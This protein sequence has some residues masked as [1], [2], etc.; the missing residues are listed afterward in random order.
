MT[1]DIHA[2]VVILVE[3]NMKNEIK[4]KHYRRIRVRMGRVED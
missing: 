4:K 3:V 2:Y 1:Y